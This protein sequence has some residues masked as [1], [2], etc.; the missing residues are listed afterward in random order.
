MIASTEKIL[1]AYAHVAL[2]RF[3]SAEEFLLVMDDNGV[4]KAHICT[5]ET[6]PD[7]AELSRAAVA[8]PGRFRVSGLPLGS[9]PEEVAESVWAQV[10]SGFT[11]LRISDALI[12]RQPELLEILG[13]TGA[14]PFVVGEGGFPAA[15]RILHSF[16]ERHRSAVVCAPHFA[17]VGPVTVF[18]T[19][20]DVAKLFAHPRFLV[21]FSRHGAYDPATLIPWAREIIKRVGFG[22]IMFGSEYPVAL[23]RDETYESTTRWAEKAGIEMTPADRQAFVHDNARRLLFSRPAPA[24]A[25][26]PIDAKWCNLRPQKQTPVQLFNQRTLKFPEETN[27]ALLSTYLAHGGE[28]S[29]S[30][31]EFVARMLAQT[32]KY[33]LAK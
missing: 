33:M 28:R 14:T 22:R 1:D 4:E 12:A 19:N 17:G 9:T 11:G 8:Y 6:C 32:V 10:N 16:L 20:A 27:R 30:Y 7:L 21:I 15:A 31:R 24:P 29:G 23:Y 25:P 18:E 2:P 3:M 5:A 26:V 13:S